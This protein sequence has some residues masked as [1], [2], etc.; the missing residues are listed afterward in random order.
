VPRLRSVLVAPLLALAVAGG[1]LT[2]CGGQGSGTSCGVDGCTVTF[3]RS[4]PAEVS[5]LGVT[6]R[7]VGVDANT[8]R[9]EVAGQ[10]VTVPIGGQAQVGGFTARVEQ[11]TDSQVVVK[12]SP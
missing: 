5:V 9:V 11:V 7:L 12:I 6:A 1:V 4:G 2:G 8:A 3:S 10:T